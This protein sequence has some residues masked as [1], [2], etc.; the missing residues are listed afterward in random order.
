M[1]IFLS[2]LL[3]TAA[4]LTLAYFIFRTEH[5]TLDDN[6]RAS[7]SG[8]F[9]RLSKGMVHYQLGGNPD[10]PLVVLVH[11]F[12]TP[13]Y[14]WDPTYQT[15][16]DSGFSVLRFDL[17]GRGY[18][19]RPVVDYNI[20]LFVNQLGEL[21]EKL[22][23]TQPVHL[24][25]LS[26]GGP[27]VAEYAN[28]HPESLRSLTLID[29][30]VTNMF[31]SGTFPLTLP[32]VGEYLMAVVMEPFYLPHSQSGDLVHP[33]NFPD[34]ESQYKVQTRYK[35]FGQAVLSTMRC[36]A[37]DDTLAIYKALAEKGLPILII[38]G[39]EDQTI[40]L[41]DINLLR[42]MVP[43]HQFHEIEAAGHIPHYEQPQVVNPLLAD[44]FAQNG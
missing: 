2:I 27:I 22:E 6:A 30:L 39:K 17:Y 19:D 32:G 4:L 8:Q 21:L 37:K 14:I 18:S 1:K 3:I 28:R 25:G 34:W 40:S 23:I 42:E 12:S 20:D 10:E 43:E 29:P 24:V 11:G 41:E 44:F 35:G 38:R 7:A 15:L 9:I 36:I 31:A 5:E 26:M 16:I 13:S 33:E